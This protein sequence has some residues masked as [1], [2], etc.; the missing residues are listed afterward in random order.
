MLDADDQE[1]WDAAIHIVNKYEDANITREQAY[2]MVLEQFLATKPTMPE[3]ALLGV[4]ESQSRQKKSQ[5][6]G[7]LEISRYTSSSDS[8]EGDGKDEKWPWSR[9][10]KDR[11]PRG[12][13]DD[14]IQA[15]V[16]GKSEK[17]RDA[18]CRLRWC[19]CFP[20]TLWTA[21]LKHGYVDFDKLNGA[22]V[23]AVDEEEG[24]AANI[25]DHTIGLK[26]KSPTKPV[27]T[28]TD[29]IYC[30][31]TYERAYAGRSTIV[32]GNSANTSTKFRQL[33]RAM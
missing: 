25:G 11:R 32:K 17:A 19:A 29:W 18:D 13:Q 26:T 31:G 7:E 4:G 1:R 21:V 6:R 23:Y 10:E 33:S 27:T 15:E 8:G 14:Q 24:Q 16:R 2:A 5:E 3:P 20:E 30:C 28:P 22:H 12:R 9:K